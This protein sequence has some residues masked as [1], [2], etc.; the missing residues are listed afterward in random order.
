MLSTRSR[1]RLRSCE[2]LLLPSLPLSPPLLA[3]ICLDPRLTTMMDSIL[4]HPEESESS[5][6]QPSLN[7]DLST[8]LLASQPKSLARNQLRQSHTD[9]TKRSTMLSGIGKA[10][11]EDEDQLMMEAGSGPGKEAVIRASLAASGPSQYQDQEELLD[12]ESE[13]GS[14][15]L[16]SSDSTILSLS[17]TIQTNDS[18]DLPYD[19]ESQ[20]D[21]SLGISRCVTP[22]GSPQLPNFDLSPLQGCS[23]TARL[24]LRSQIISTDRRLET[25]AI[26]S[27]AAQRTPSR[28]VSLRRTSSSS[29]TT[30]NDLPDT[31]LKPPLLA[32]SLDMMTPLARGASP[33]QEEMDAFFGF[34]DPNARS[35]SMHSPSLPASR[36]QEEIPTLSNAEDPVR[37]SASP[38]HTFLD[39]P[40]PETISYETARNADPAPTE[41]TMRESAHRD[42][43][44]VLDDADDEI[45]QDPNEKR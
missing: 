14:I 34:V 21:S 11:E 5:P 23:P 9:Y 32:S 17:Q 29:S 41:Q 7:F 42:I 30:L 22:I 43:G 13:D 3:S 8:S 36:H 2:S 12:I 15:I 10:R 16:D 1:N 38:P 45:S 26:T 31:S 33:T 25:V 40:S 44:N 35:V 24:S 6:S 39:P 20:V 27:N 37:Q 4:D 18:D 28:Q 19:T